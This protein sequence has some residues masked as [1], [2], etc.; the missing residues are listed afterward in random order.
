MVHATS[1]TDKKIKSKSEILL[2]SKILECSRI[3]VLYLQGVF[4]RPRKISDYDYPGL[5]FQIFFLFSS[6]ESLRVCVVLIIFVN[7]IK[8]LYSNV[9]T[10]V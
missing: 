5:L 10:Y 2:G 8:L 7:N 1:G 9:C 6:L 4:A 3:Y